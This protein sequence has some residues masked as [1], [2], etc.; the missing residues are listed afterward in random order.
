MAAQRAANLAAFDDANDVG[1]SGGAC[2]F[3]SL[4]LLCCDVA[5]RR[6]T[7][8]SATRRAQVGVAAVRQLDRF[9]TRRVGFL[10]RARAKSQGV[11]CRIRLD[12]VPYAFSTHFDARCE[13]R[14]ALRDNPHTPANPCSRPLLL[15]GLAPADETL[16]FVQAR[17]KRHRSAAPRSMSRS[18]C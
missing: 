17:L 4:S 15:G 14:F 13:N 16:G 8:L 5:E 11:Y 2:R 12:A 1:G 3:F 18:S 10:I 7:A 9:A 6:E